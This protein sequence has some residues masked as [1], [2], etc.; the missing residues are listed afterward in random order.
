MN[1]NLWDSNYFRFVMRARIAAIFLS[2]NGSKCPC[3]VCKER[4]NDSW[5]EIRTQTYHFPNPGCSPRT[6]RH[7]H[8]KPSRGHLLKPSRPAFSNFNNGAKSRSNF[9]WW[10]NHRLPS[11]CSRQALVQSLTLR[12]RTRTREAPRRAKSVSYSE[13]IL[14]PKKMVIREPMNLMQMEK[15]H[16]S[17]RC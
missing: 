5:E 15:L 17:S 3:L 6:Q 16:Q 4:M 7:S 10:A 8:W 11:T 13:A 12:S 2:N 14:Q 9:P 1:E